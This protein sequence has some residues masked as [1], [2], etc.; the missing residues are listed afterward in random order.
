MGEALCG[1]HE[2]GM[3]LLQMEENVTKLHRIIEHFMEFMWNGRKW[4][5]IVWKGVEQWVMV[6]NGGK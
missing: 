1:T 3:K 4:C 6:K 5:E 2:N